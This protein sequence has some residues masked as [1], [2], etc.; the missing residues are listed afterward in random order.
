MSKK[1]AVLKCWAVGQHVEI[2][3]F[4]MT[5]KKV[6]PYFTKV[7]VCMW[8]CGCVL[9]SYSCKMDQIQSYGFIR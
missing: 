1:R 8:V 6:L 5:R 9:D 4:V 2:L 7:C 3:C